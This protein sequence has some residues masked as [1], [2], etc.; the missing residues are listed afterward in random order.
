VGKCARGIEQRQTLLNLTELHQ[1]MAAQIGCEQ[2]PIWEFGNERLLE[3]EQRRKRRASQAT[4]EVA[5]AAEPLEQIEARESAAVARPGILYELASRL[6]D[7]PRPTV[8]DAQEK[9]RGNAGRLL[10]RNGPAAQ[11]ARKERS[12]FLEATREC[13]R[14]HHER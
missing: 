4:G 9:P 6:L 14:A 3:S 13:E 1:R 8:G 12:C 10:V 11:R 5:I 2:T 7:A